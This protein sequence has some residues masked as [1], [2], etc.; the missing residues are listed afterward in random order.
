MGSARPVRLGFSPLDEELALLPGSLCAWGHE[1]LVRL[2]TWMPFEEAAKLL[3][4]MLGIQVSECMA[5]RYTEAA[6]AAQVALE[7]EAV[8]D[9]EREAPAAPAGPAKQ[10][11]S[12]DGAYVPLVAGKWAEVKTL[13]IGEVSEPVLDAKSNTWSVSSTKLSYFSRLAEAQTFNRLALVE[14][15]RRGVENAQQVAAVMDG[16]EWLQG[17]VAYHRADARR[18]LDFPHAAEYVSKIGQAAYGADTPELAAWLPTQ[19]HELKHS[20]PAPVLAELRRLTQTHPAAH[21]LG[22]PEA[23][24]YLEKRQAQM[25]YP[26]F[27][28]QGWPIGSGAVES[29]NKLVVE[30]RLKGAGMHWAPEHVN[31]M[32]ALR[33]TVCNDRWA[34]IWPQIETRLRLQ[35]RQAQ[36]VRLQKRQQ[37]RLPTP[38]PSDASLLSPQPSAPL[39]PPLPASERPALPSPALSTG[40]TEPPVTHPTSTP[41]QPRTHSPAPDHP[42]RRSPIGRARFRPFPSAKPGKL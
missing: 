12:A 29:A 19:L 4:V 24:A 26:T 33:N 11:I 27:Q 36:T 28:A 8:A 1:C 21:S 7:T 31:P 16:A 2:A 39:P 22:L 30:D 9:L 15:H 34:E 20:G 23:L 18:I 32:L 38:L 37:Q 6:G 41:T 5:R 42:W 35:A 10:M 40:T 14:T 3:A 25:Q 13:V 17:F